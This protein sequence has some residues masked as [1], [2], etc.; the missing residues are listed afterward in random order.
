M[1][2]VLGL[3]IQ[4]SIAREKNKIEDVKERLPKNGQTR[5][6][7]HS[8]LSRKKRQG[9]EPSNGKTTLSTNFLKQL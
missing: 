1:P 3:M 6:L 9:S 4:Q 5:I 7:N 8:N 2:Y